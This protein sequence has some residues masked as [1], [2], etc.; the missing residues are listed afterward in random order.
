M[1]PGKLTAIRRQNALSVSAKRPGV[2]WWLQTQ[3]FSCNAQVCRRCTR[4][5]CLQDD[6]CIISS[7]RCFSA[8]T[9]N[10]PGS[11]AACSINVSI[12]P[13]GEGARHAAR[14]HGLPLWPPERRQSLTTRCSCING[15]V[16]HLFISL[17]WPLIRNQKTYRYP[18]AAVAPGSTSNTM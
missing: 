13:R 18:T 2:I 9:G 17:S 1:R 15:F 5:L 3:P 11:M 10:A 6:G 4:L 16:L 12:C 8:A 14:H 7:R